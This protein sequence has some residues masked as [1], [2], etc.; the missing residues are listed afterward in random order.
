L[1]D[2]KALIK[3]CSFENRYKSLVGK[4]NGLCGDIHLHIDDGLSKEARDDPDERDF[5]LTD[6]ADNLR[7]VN[8]ADVDCLTGL[9]KMAEGFRKRCAG[10]KN[11]KRMAFQAFVRKPA[12]D[13]VKAMHGSVKDKE[14][15]EYPCAVVVAPTAIVPPALVP[16]VNPEAVKRRCTSKQPGGPAFPTLPEGMSKECFEQ[17]FQPHCNVAVTGTLGSSRTSVVRPGS[18]IGNRK[19]SCCNGGTIGAIYLVGHLSAGKRRRR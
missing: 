1:F 11:A 13:N 3:K 5:I 12:E 17:G 18:I 6:V 4:V 10:N 16:P 14:V 19:G 7:D 8:N 2:I 9:V 15:V